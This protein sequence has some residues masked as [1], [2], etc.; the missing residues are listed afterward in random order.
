ME[1]KLLE[2][3]EEKITNNK[4]RGVIKW[5]IGIGITLIALIVCLAV[6]V[7][8]ALLQ[9]TD[10]LEEPNLAGLT[11]PIFAGPTI[12][13]HIAFV[14][15]DSNI[16]L[17]SP[18]GEQIR[19]LTK[20][21]R[22]YRFPTWAPDGRY[23]AFVGPNDDDKTVL[24][25]S[26]ASESNPKIIFDDEKSAPFY[27]YWAPDSQTITFLT[28]ES[29]GLSMR[30][31]SANRPDNQRILEEGAPFYWVW[32]PSGDKLLMHVGGSRALSEKAH[33][34]I[35]ENQSNAQRIELDTAPGR[36][37]APAWST[38]GSHFFYIAANENGRE[39]IFKIN[40][41]TLAQTV[42][43]NLSGFVYF[44]LSPNNNN[45]AYLQ[46][47]RGNRPPFGNAYV[48][49]TDGKGQK[50]VTDRLVASMYWSPDGSKLALL[51]LA[52]N[53]DGSSAKTGGL[54][55]P[56][57]QKLTLRWWIY[58]IESGD[59]EPLIS[60]NPTTAFLQTVPYFDQY[61]LSLT[62]WSPDSRYFVI[63]KEDPSG[64]DGT[65]WVIDTTDQTEPRQVGEGTLAVWS[66]H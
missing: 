27:L 22:G 48:V 35:L 4:S 45:I 24:Y 32:S 62:F 6:I 3:L 1:F 23:L 12:R 51:T 31:V 20:D 63:T 21:S 53:N 39:S 36:F 47:E 46:I 41:E 17:V 54:A 29:S 8:F 33:I 52:R 15:N 57:R 30:Q 28:Q 64:A 40:A 14:G 44:V 10:R 5:I 43:T 19:F 50:Q 55:A 2:P 65:V 61:H 7:Y 11:A 25:V 60:F 16:W 66:W 49:G 18:D 9:I 42:V 26:P 58:H 38:D 56:L 37:Q 34:S 13:N 59:L